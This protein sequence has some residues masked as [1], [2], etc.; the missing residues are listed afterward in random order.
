MKKIYIAIWCDWVSEK[1]LCAAYNLKRCEN[2]AKKICGEQKL[3]YNG[4]E[5]DEKIPFD[6]YM[7]CHNVDEY[8]TE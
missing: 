4:V 7:G 6:D 1:N 8:Y 2:L 3:D 5:Y